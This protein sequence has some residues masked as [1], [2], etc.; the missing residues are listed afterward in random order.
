MDLR[1]SVRTKRIALLLTGLVASTSLLSAQEKLTLDECR[2]MA[3]THSRVLQQKDAEREAAHARKQEVFT[4]F[5][6]QVTARGAYLHMQKEFHL[7]DWDKP[8]GSFN[9]LIP[10][11]LRHLGTVDL[12]NVWVANVTAIQP[13]YLGG[14]I[15]TGYQMASLAE[16]LQDNL[17]ETAA[18][19]IE[20]KVDETYWQI[21]SLDSKSRLLDQLVTLLTQTVRDVDA[22]IAAGVATKADGLS[23]R[24]KLSEAEVKRS[25]VQNGLELSKMLL[26]DLCGLESSADIHLAD[27]GQIELALPAPTE[28]LQAE[29]FPPPSSAAAKC[30]PCVWSTPSIASACVWR[31]LSFCLR[32]T[33]SPAIR[34]RIPIASVARRWNLAG[35]ITSARCF[36][37]LSLTSSQAPSAVVRLRPSTASSSSSSPKPAVRSPCR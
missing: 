21:I 10:D 9:F 12:R 23:V 25:Q 24:T 16:Q 28:R 13:I 29:T 18:T 36:R 8:L 6:P 37:Y 27:E 20:T 17:R 33:A 4:K 11:R 3:K 7:I 15:T 34:L 19:E 31:R 35:S 32:S 5:F 2:E 14:K 26:A 22:S 30:A 1:L